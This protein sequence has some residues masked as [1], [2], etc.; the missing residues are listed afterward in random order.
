[1]IWLGPLPAF[2]SYKPSP[3]F[4]YLVKPSRSRFLSESFCARGVVGPVTQDGGASGDAATRLSGFRMLR[5][6]IGAH[7]LHDFEDLSL[8]AII[9]NALVD[10][11]GHRSMLRVCVPGVVGV[12]LRT[13]TIKGGLV[14]FRQRQIFSDPSSQIGVGNQQPTKHDRIATAR[15]VRRFGVLHRHASPRHVP[16]LAVLTIK[17]LPKS[18]ADGIESRLALSDHEAFHHIKMV[19]VPFGQGIGQSP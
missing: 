18:G 5:E 2:F 7:G 11:S 4:W 16:A 8:G 9:L 13:T 6:R 1:M 10:V 19:Q 12:S 14:G 15:G 17:S 3:A